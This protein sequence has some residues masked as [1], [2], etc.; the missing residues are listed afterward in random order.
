MN[1][2]A[3]DSSTKALLKAMLVYLSEDDESEDVPR[4]TN[5]VE[6]D[7]SKLNPFKDT[8]MEAQGQLDALSPNSL[9]RRKFEAKLKS[10]KQKADKWEKEQP[11]YNGTTPDDMSTGEYREYRLQQKIQPQR[12]KS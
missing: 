7:A 11:H 1:N 12:D 3:K 9:S 2:L 10:A 4:E 8:V 5:E 6:L